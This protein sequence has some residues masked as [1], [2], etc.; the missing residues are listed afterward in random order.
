MTLVIYELWKNEKSVWKA[1]TE[2]NLERGFVQQIIQQSATFSSGVLHFCENLEE[3]WP[4][5]TL[6]QELMKR[7][8]FNCSSAELLPLLELDCVKAGRAQQL[9]NAGFKT[10]ETIASTKMQDIVEK[11]KNLPIN[12]AKRIINSAGRILTE[13][14][15]ALQAQAEDLLLQVTT[16]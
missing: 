9:Y 16:E 11:I 5:K 10:I 2:F 3:F 13:R 8:Q 6:L 1:S 7:L 14:A 12:T 4:Y 15:E